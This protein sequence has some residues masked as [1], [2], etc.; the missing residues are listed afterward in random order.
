VRAQIAGSDGATAAV[1]VHAGSKMG[2]LATVLWD[3]EGAWQVR[4]RVT[5]LDAGP[6]HFH[7]QDLRKRLTIQIVCSQWL[8]ALSS[9]NGF[10]G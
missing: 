10:P 9:S 8:P 3:S 1:L 5:L 7:I 6:D 4:P 2:G